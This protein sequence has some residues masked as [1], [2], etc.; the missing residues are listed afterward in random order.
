MYA[1]P[2]ICVQVDV[3]QTDPPAL[4]HFVLALMVGYP[5]S[6]FERRR[7]ETHLFH[8]L[9]AVQIARILVKVDGETSC[10]LSEL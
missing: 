6:P 5:F 4:K 3:K 2:C 8:G 1:S 9:G 7:I 10:I